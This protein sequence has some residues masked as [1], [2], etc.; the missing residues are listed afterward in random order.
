MRAGLDLSVQISQQTGTD[1]WIGLFVLMGGWGGVFSID[2]WSQ[3]HI[4]VFWG[5][6]EFQIALCV[7]LT[8]GDQDGDGLYHIVPDLTINPFVSISLMLSNIVS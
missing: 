3:S 6:G 8:G 1:V 2:C 7:I 5:R 4:S